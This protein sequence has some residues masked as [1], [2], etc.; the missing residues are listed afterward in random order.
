MDLLDELCSLH[1]DTA[2][3]RIDALVW[4]RTPMTDEEEAMY[5][6]N[7]SPATLASLAADAVA[8]SLNVRDR[9]KLHPRHL[10]QNASDLV[11]K[12]I[13]DKL[14][15]DMHRINVATRLIEEWGCVP[16]ALAMTHTVMPK[17]HKRA[18]A[19]IQG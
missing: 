14:M 15:L 7:K 10:T 16:C 11:S 3:P 6:Y 17:F 13:Y 19:F 18:E 8:A 5:P 2:G 1:S 12:S 4:A 9:S